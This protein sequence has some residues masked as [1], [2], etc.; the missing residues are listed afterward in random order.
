MI[1][2]N[3]NLRLPFD[4]FIILFHREELIPYCKNKYYNFQINLTNEII[5][6]G[7]AW[8]FRTDHAGIDLDIALLGLNVIFQIYDN[9]HWDDEKGEYINHE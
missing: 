3:F 2:T 1:N 5:G 4:R 9:R 7:F 8:R 6:F